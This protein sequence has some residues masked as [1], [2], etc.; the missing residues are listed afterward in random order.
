[1]RT[2]STGRT[3]RLNIVVSESLAREVLHLAETRG[4]TLSR[5]IR[6]AVEKECDRSRER[7]LA[8]A[9]EGLAPLY[10]A[11]SDLTSFAALDSE[12]FL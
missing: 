6:D 5:F 12:D 3:R 10:A 7:I 4:V 8:D 2:A 9:A 1:M 11:G